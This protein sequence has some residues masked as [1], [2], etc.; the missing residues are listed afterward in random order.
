MQIR[1]LQVL[2]N[3]CLHIWLK[4]SANSVI[5]S[6]ENDTEGEITCLLPHPIQF[7]DQVFRPQMRIPLEHLHG[8][9]PTDGRHFL[10]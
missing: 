4:N 6:L 8:F 2:G 7:L 9:V 1:G 10:V 5:S 3:T